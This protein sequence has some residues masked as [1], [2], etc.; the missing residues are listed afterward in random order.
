MANLFRTSQHSRQLSRLRFYSVTVADR[1]L[2]ITLTHGARETAPASCSHSEHLANFTIRQAVAR[3]G[4]GERGCITAGSLKGTSRY[5]TSHH[6]SSK[7]YLDTRQCHLCA[8]EVLAVDSESMK[9]IVSLIVWLTRR[10]MPA[11]SILAS[12]WAQK[13]A[14]CLSVSA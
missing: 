13:Q 2:V 14:L 4:G 1:S 11:V 12:E 5:C 10:S 3:K 6:S 7:Q 9:T 8:S